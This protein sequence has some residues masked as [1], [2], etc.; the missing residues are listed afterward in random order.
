MDSVN[1]FRQR[2]IACALAWA[3]CVP[4][5]IGYGLL[6][7]A[8]LST[9]ARGGEGN[10]PGIAFVYLCFVCGWFAWGALAVMSRAWLVD[11]P[12]GPLLPIVGTVAAC[13]GLLP[14]VS[15]W[16]PL[17][18]VSPGVALACWLALW[19]LRAAFKR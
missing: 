18:L 11:R 6:S 4:G 15:P 16:P 12:R 3:G 13:L 17:V 2:R 7:L 10:L 1:P 14:L 8:A 5:L 9:A 19:H